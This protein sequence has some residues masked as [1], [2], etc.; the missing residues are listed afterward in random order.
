MHI[1]YLNHSSLNAK[2]VIIRAVLVFEISS[3]ELLF[4]SVRLFYD[5]YSKKEHLNNVS[6]WVIAN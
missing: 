5:K 6:L 2:I 3:K 1:L 4:R